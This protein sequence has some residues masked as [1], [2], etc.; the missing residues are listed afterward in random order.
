[1]GQ[2]INALPKAY[3]IE[4]FVRPLASHD[5]GAPYCATV[6]TGWLSAPVPRVLVLCPIA[7]HELGWRAD[8]FQF[9]TYRDAAGSMMAETQWWR[10][11]L[12]QPIDENSSWAEGQRVVFTPE[13]LEIFK[14]RFGPQKRLRRSWRKARVARDPE[15]GGQNRASE[16]VA[17][18]G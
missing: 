8:T 9:H 11:G 5:V 17:A 7:A 2:A 18:L 4:P 6:N 16:I 15:G 3:K 1:M 10:E 13:G 14:A 12:E